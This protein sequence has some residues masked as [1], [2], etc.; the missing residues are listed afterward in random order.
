MA[1][2]CPGCGAPI[3]RSPDSWLLRCPACGALLAARALDGGGAA[4]RYEVQVA[5]RPETRTVVEVPWSPQDAR[6]LRAWLVWSTAITLG[7]IGVLYAA[8]RLLR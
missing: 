5:R 3:G 8:A 4:R 6:R 2:A 1:F 7:L